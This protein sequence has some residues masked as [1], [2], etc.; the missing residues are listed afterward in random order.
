[1][2]VEDRSGRVEEVLDE[3]LDYLKRETLSEEVLLEKHEEL[4]TYQ[5]GEKDISIAI[6]KLS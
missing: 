3:W 5:I 1:L 2:Y 6:E 4:K